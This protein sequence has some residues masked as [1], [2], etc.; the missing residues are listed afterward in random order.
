[1]IIRYQEDPDDPKSL[2]INIEDLSEDEMEV[3]DRFR[4]MI[5]NLNFGIA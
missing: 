2:I 5:E 1:M 3:Y 4:Q